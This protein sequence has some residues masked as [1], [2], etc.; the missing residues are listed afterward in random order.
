MDLC[1]RAGR[2]TT[3]LFT[4][5]AG[6]LVAAVV[7]FLGGMTRRLQREAHALTTL[8]YSIPSHHHKEVPA[9]ARAIE[10]GGATLMQDV[11]RE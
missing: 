7:L 6:S 9:I 1:G 8:L 11:E 4:A 10:S 2:Q 5:L 3:L